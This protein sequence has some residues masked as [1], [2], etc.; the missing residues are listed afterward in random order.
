MKQSKPYHVSWE[1]SPQD[2]QEVNR[3]LSLQLN[4]IDEMFEDIYTH[5][6]QAD[7]V[8]GSSSTSSTDVET[9][10]WTPTDASGASLTFTNPTGRYIKIDELV[11]ATG[12]LTFPSTASGANC[13][14][15]GFPF[16]PLV[17]ANLF[18]GGFIVSSDEA[19]AVKLW[20]N[21]A[22][23]SFSPLSA[24]DNFIT[25]VTFT[26]N[27]IYFTLVYRTTA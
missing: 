21:G 1:D 27:Y 23:D 5:M 2:I 19:T 10:T 15:A 18:W 12:G 9:G 24:S 14:I 11:I 17:T 7:D 25:N 8:D 22:G 3:R 16:T 26:T 20:I 4:H 13:K 6:L